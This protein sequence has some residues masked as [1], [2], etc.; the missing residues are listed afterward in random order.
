MI[1]TVA[2]KAMRVG[3]IVMGDGDKPRAAGWQF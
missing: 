3:A 1:R 2:S